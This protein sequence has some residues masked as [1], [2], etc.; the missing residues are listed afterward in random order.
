MKI[1]VDTNILFSFFWKESITRKLIIN[2]RDNLLSSEKAKEE[3]IK[4]SKEICKKIKISLEEFNELLKELEDNVD[5]IEK[6]EYAEVI[7]NVSN[8]NLDEEDFEF[9]A[10]AYKNKCALWTN[11]SALK[12]QQIVKIITTKDL[13]ED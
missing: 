7:K 11:D 12:N 8:P 2:L 6:K 13:L 1:V 10:L 3:L 9:L 4:Y 5:F